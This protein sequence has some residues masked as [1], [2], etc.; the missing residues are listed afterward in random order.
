MKRFGGLA[1]AFALLGEP[2]LARARETPPTEGVSKKLRLWSGSNALTVPDGRWEFGLFGSSHYGLTDSVELSLHPLLVVAL[3]HLEAKFMAAERHRSAVALRTRLGIPPDAFVVGAFGGITAEKRVPQL[4]QAVAALD[5]SGAPVHV[6]LA[7]Q[8]AAHYD[9]DRNIRD[10]G[11]DGRVHVAGYVPDEELVTAM[12]A[13]DI[14]ACLRWPSNGETSAS[15]LRALGAG[16]PTIVTALA[17][18]QNVPAL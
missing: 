18:L 5:R 13:S 12:A 7:G 8:R 15:W 10:A 3:P 2:S 1:L 4:L 14:C 16:R 9:V 6:L 11:L 17:H